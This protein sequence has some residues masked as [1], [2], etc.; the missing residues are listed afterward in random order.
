MVSG[1]RLVGATRGQGG[2]RRLWHLGIHP[3]P[4]MLG[5]GAAHTPHCVDNRNHK[6]AI[7]VSEAV[8][9]EAR[10]GF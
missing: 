1:E 6:I 2:R 8:N 5:D 4:S 9:K 10:A 7:T 3:Q